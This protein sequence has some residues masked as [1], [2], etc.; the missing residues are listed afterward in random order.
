M[1]K[2][3]IRLLIIAMT[4]GMVGLSAVQFYWISN[5]ITLREQ[6]FEENIYV[7]VNNTIDEIEKQE[8]A[9]QFRTGSR[10]FFRNL[11]EYNIDSLTKIV[12]FEFDDSAEQAPDTTL[13]LPNREVSRPVGDTSIVF[14]DPGGNFQEYIHYDS[15]ENRREYQ[16]L[17]DKDDQKMK[18]N[19][20]QQK[21]TNPEEFR[22]GMASYLKQAGF[23]TAIFQDFIQ[24]SYN[25]NIE[26]RISRAVVDS[27]LRKELARKGVTADY[28]FA[29]WSTDRQ[30][31]ALMKP[32]TDT[33]AIM[34]SPYRF[35]LFPQSF[36]SNPDI[37]LLN[38]PGQRLY[39][40]KTMWGTLLVSAIM[41]III[42]F[43]FQYTITNIVRQKKLSDMKNDFINNMT[44]ELKTPIST[45][46]L[47][48]Q[49]LSDRDIQK[50]EGMYTNYVR[51]IDEENKRLAVLTEN[52]L[53]TAL[54]DRG[55]L[56]LR[57]E[58]VD[59]HDIVETCIHG[60]DLLI[61]KR[62]GK[63]ITVLEATNQQ[64]FI[65]PFH[66]GNAIQNLLDNA[67]KYSA[68]VPEII[69]QSQNSGS[70]VVISV[71]DNGIG[72][73][74]ADQKRIFEKFFRIPTGNLHN[75]KGYGLG[76]S[77][78]KAIVEMHQ[79]TVTVESESGKGSRFSIYLPHEQNLT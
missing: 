64:V 39:V 24:P 52:V 48:C 40:I 10:D 8:V 2:R 7:A 31:L 42:I 22:K 15:A 37:L 68:G 62:G 6:Q 38:F 9:N 76:L 66:I 61:E 26:D 65:D 3:V 71:G 63:I 34:N 79:G 58:W 60:T 35:T 23:G 43:I 44:H 45:I 50:T 14:M 19:I 25:P 74:K 41:I 4:F 32:G 55:Q 77:Y 12:A 33:S 70:G 30:K 54:I 11:F 73:S 67:N 46:S 57:K 51:I 17:Y 1:N 47:A 27:L 16:L 49:A 21:F 13:S 56:R 29:I 75:A 36:F 53:Q 28:D 5:A 59:I 20:I 18:A 72:I 78:V 69:V